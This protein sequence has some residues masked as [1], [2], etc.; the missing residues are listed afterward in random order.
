METSLPRAFQVV[1]DEH[2]IEHHEKKGSKPDA[3]DKPDVNQRLPLNG[4]EKLDFGYMAMK[5]YV[6]KSRQSLAAGGKKCAVC[7]SYIRMDDDLLLVCEHNNCSAVSHLGCLSKHFTRMPIAPNQPMI[8]VSGS[9]PSCKKSSRWQT[10]VKELSLR[11]RGEKELTKIFK[12]PRVR[13]AGVEASTMA[14]EEEVMTTEEL[15]E[16]E[17]EEFIDLENFEAKVL[18]D[19]FVDLEDLEARMLIKSAVSKG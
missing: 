9:C 17:D 16:S 5:E 14:P 4:V 8:P 11:T 6:E 12:K 19:S 15:E 10:L 7:S 1:L 13:K 18:E 3:L 2:A